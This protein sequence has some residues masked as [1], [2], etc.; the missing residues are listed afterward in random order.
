MKFNLQ[1]QFNIYVRCEDVNSNSNND[2]YIVN[3][4]IQE[5]PD[6][7]AADLTD[8]DPEDGSFLKYNETEQLLTIKLNEPVEC[9]WDH[10]NVDYGS[11]TAFTNCEPYNPNSVQ[12]RW[13][14]STILEGLT[15]DENKVYIRCKDQPWLSIP[16]V[17]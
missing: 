16:G 5:G 4:C 13:E 11:M 3:L 17:A 15:E 7:T 6:N 14:C 12:S 9:R 2:E 10:N 8:F 1:G